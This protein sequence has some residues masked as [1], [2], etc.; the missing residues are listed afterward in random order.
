[1][2]V[3]QIVETTK[4]GLIHAEARSLELKAGP[5]GVFAVFAVDSKAHA[6]VVLR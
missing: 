5:G 3:R 6:G 4:S 1:V 2:H